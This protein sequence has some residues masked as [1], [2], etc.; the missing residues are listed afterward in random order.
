MCD[1]PLDRKEELSTLQ[2]K[3]VI[4]DASVAGART[5]VF[6]GGEPLL[7]EDIF[8]LI[9]YVKNNSLNA[10]I[11]SNGYSIDDV[12]ASRLSQAGVDVVNISI[13]G[14]RD[15][16]DNL[17]GYG[18]FDKAVLALENLKKYGVE[19]TVATIV[20]IWN[21]KYLSY[22]VKLAR[23]YAATTIKFQP[24]NRIF[25]RNRHDSDNFLISECEIGTVAQVMSEAVKLCDAYGIATNPRTYLE[26]IPLYLGEKNI[27]SNF[28]CDALWMSCSINCQG[29]IY[30]CWVLVEDDKLIGT[31]REDS[32]LHIWDSQ[33]RRSL[34]ERINREGCPVCMMSCYDKNFGAESIE[35]RIEMNVKR[36][37]EKGL[38]EYVHSL[39]K[40]WAKRARFY[41]TYRGSFGRIVDR[42]KGSLKNKSMQKVGISLVEIDRALGEIGI[43][44]QILEKEVRGSR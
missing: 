6:S 11:T 18:A 10:C 17:R 25:L 5:I 40:R 23:D 16:H 2:W 27:D 32:F 22:V 41:A 20:S 35:R 3:Q 36:L 21:Y 24:F 33:R 44:K 30:P 8:E 4:R 14:P 13:E 39:L 42:C 34:I 31:V 28:G 9:S 29:E 38:D 43:A 1:I 12:V 7:R 26:K 15:I 37:R 19:T